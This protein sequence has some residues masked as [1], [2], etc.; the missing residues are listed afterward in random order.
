VPPRSPQI[1]V[2]R[3]SETRR[4]RAAIRKRESL[5]IVGPAGIGK[6][7]LVLKVLEEFSVDSP[8][9]FLYFAGIGGVRDLL[10]C[11]VRRLYE[12]GDPTLRCQLHAEGINRTTFKTWLDNQS[13]SRL[14]G[15]LYRAVEKNH[16]WIFLDHFPALTAATA[17]VVKELVLVRNTPV[18][19]VARGFSER[20]GGHWAGL[21]W[22]QQ[23]RLTLPPLSLKA[24]R[25]LLESCI[26]F[27][28]LLKMNLLDFRPEVLRWSEGVP[29]AIVKMCEL[30]SS[31]RYQ[32]GTRIKTKLLH[33]DYLTRGCVSGSSGYEAGE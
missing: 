4:L 14:K 11:V 5:M 27:Y 20:E 15:S 23:Q 17:K 2:G 30:A 22:S 7:T 29:E 13:T 1:F 18:Y 21:F 25:D 9:S 31:S 33:I 24:A 10:R 32:F 8:P 16:Y 19:L 3:E 12:S 28:G 6:T 26:S